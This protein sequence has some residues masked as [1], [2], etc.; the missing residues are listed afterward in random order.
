MPDTH[1][2]KIR[3]IP[4]LAEQ[5]GN[6]QSPTERMCFLWTHTCFNA[7]MLSSG[8]LQGVRL[9]DHCSIVWHKEIVQHWM[10]WGEMMWCEPK[11]E[12]SHS[13]IPV[14][15][16][17]FTGHQPSTGFGHYSCQTGVVYIGLWMSLVPWHS[18][19]GDE[20]F[21]STSLHL[22]RQRRKEVIGVTWEIEARG[23]DRSAGIWQ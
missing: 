14:D 11:R 8:T 16:V 17:S 10:I 9:S 15:S 21:S 6:M 2:C 20:V 12:L 13:S 18:V 1:F 23:L 5:T 7:R 19:I 4:R 22:G 3:D